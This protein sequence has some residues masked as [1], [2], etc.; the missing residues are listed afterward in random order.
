GVGGAGVGGT[1]VGGARVG[2]A[3]VGGT[4]VGGAGVGG[5]RVGGTGVGRTGVGGARV[6][7]ARVGGDGV[8]V[9]VPTHRRPELVVGAVEAALGQTVAV[10]EVV[11]VVDA[12]G[13]GAEETEA[14]LSAIGDQRVRVVR[15]PGRGG[16]SQARNAGVAVT[17]APWVAFCDD[18][19]RWLPS[20][21]ARQLDVLAR[22]GWPPDA[23]VSTGVVA[24]SPGSEYRWPK[25]FVDGT[26]S[27]GEY[28]FCTR[29]PF[30]GETLLHTST[31]LASRSLLEAEPFDE[32]LRNHEDWDWLV[33]AAGR[34]ARFLAVPEHLAVWHIEEDRP[35][36]TAVTGDWERSLAWAGR[37]RGRLGER[38]YSA[39]CLTVVAG[40][41]RASGSARGVGA[42]LVAA[43]G[44]SPPVRNL[45]W[46]PFYAVLSP[47]VRR[48]LRARLTSARLPS[49]RWSARS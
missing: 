5:A 22:A 3:R 41:A 9:V 38:A 25:R 6:G 19:D 28:L 39:F 4:G 14:A 24:R 42:A 49:G 7:G 27:V 46:F 37:Q 23:V 43:L 15:R 31:L 45:L 35:G 10:D 17:S 11:V 30:Q 26:R 47:G 2:G 48:R 33:R 21:L 8:A 16:P 20:K 34:G 13:G 32:T 40:R 1:G 36:L 29:T 44:G 12:D 18:D